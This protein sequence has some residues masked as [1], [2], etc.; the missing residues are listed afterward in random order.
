MLI[1][2]FDIKEIVH[3]EFVLAGQ[4]V[5]SAHYCDIFYGDCVK[6]AKNSTPTLATEE[7]A[8]ASRQHTVSHFLFRQEIVYQIQHDCRPSPTLLLCFLD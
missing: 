2:F 7:L 3:K 8:V 4:I 5:N 1:I 6:I